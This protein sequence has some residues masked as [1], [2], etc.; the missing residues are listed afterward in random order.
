M[1][2]VATLG[3][4]PR[5]QKAYTHLINGL[6][7]IRERV[8]DRNLFVVGGIEH[9]TSDQCLNTEPWLLHRNTQNITCK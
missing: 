9:T 6:S 4:G 3:G 7:K 8:N 2:K 5:P 1:F